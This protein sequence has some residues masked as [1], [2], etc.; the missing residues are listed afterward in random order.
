[1]K[2]AATAAARKIT[3]PPQ[4][5]RKK[6]KKKKKTPK[7]HEEGSPRFLTENLFLV[8]G[9]HLELTKKKINQVLIEKG[10]KKEIQLL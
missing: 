5:R 4:K 9:L 7:V 1:M 10:G 6:S 3:S 2:R 8:P